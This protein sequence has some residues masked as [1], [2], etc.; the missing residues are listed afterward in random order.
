MK[1]AKLILDLGASPGSWSQYCLKENNS[2]K[3][4]AIDLNPLTFS[5]PRLHFVQG[6][7][8]ET[9]LSQPEKYDL[10]LSDMA[11]KT[12]GM[13]DVD[14]ANSLELSE[15]ALTLAIQHLKPGG[16][17]VVKIFMGDS[18][19]EFDRRMKKAFKEVKRLRPEST[20]KHSKEIFFIGRQLIANA[21]VG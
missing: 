7:A 21:A 19:E 17:F 11:P 2:C 12:T 8:L 15:M 4:V 10:V 16:N 6:S 1:N 14:I 5:D 20:R 3:I 18:F 13:I 9:D